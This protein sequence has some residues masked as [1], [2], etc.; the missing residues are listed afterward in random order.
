MSQRANGD[1]LRG[2]TD[3]MV[4]SVLADGPKYGYLIQ[5]RL[6]EVSHGRVDLKAGTLYPLLH[7]LESA[8]LLKSREDSTTGRKRKWYDL[9]AQ[10][11][12]RL[13]KQAT[14]WQEYARCLQKLL[15]PVLAA[16]AKAT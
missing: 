10:G 6:S 7:R 14:E 15:A 11:K 3:L 1:F 13:T 16:S 5:Q 12:R 9:T 2:S 8:K 4:L